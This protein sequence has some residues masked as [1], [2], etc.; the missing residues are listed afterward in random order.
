V[1]EGGEVIP[2]RQV[3]KI[4]TATVAALVLASLSF[5]A[6]YAWGNHWH[7]HRADPASAAFTISSVIY[8]A[9]PGA[10][11]AISCTGSPAL[12]YPG[13]TR[14]M[15]FSVHNDLSRPITVENIASQ[16][17]SAFPTPPP[18]CSGSNLSLPAFS[19]NLVVPSGATIVG[20]G[21]PI[22]LKESHSNQDA[23]KNLTYHFS[24]TG[25]ALYTDATSTV[26]TSS[27]NPSTLGKPVTFT[28]VVTATGGSKYSSLP[29][30]LVTFSQ[31]S[32]PACATS[33]P[34]GTG[35]IGNGGQTTYTTTGLLAGTTYVEAVYA[36]ANTNFTGSTSNVV[37]QVVRSTLTGTSTALTTSPNP[38][39]VGDSVLLTA[40][41]ASLA[42][43]LPRPAP[44]TGT[45]DVF[46]GTP[47]GT[48]TLLGSGP[49][50]TGE[51]AIISTSS[52][53]AGSDSLYAV[54]VGNTNFATSTSPEISQVVIA[55]P[56]KC[57]GNYSNWIDGNS[58]SPTISVTDGDNFVYLFG[59]NYFVH[60][61]DGHDCFYAGNGNNVFSDG[62]GNDCF[63]VGDG[64]NA[65]SDGNGNDVVVAGK[66]NN[67]VTEGNGSDQITVGNGDNTVTVGN[68]SNSGIT[69]GNGTDDVTVGSG[70][71][72]RVTLGSGT[73]VVKIQGGSY[74]TITSGNGNETIYLGAGSYDTYDGGTHVTN[75]CHLPAPP[76]SWHGTAA[77]YY[78]DTITNCTVETS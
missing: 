78:H 21:L 70:S 24:F 3:R 28:A 29:T 76:S 38:S 11:P 5:T 27:P 49:L 6:A 12:L 63:N 10:F 73:D 64:N 52:L 20:P 17:S 75:V 15:V 47:T 68:G 74:D 1:T 46:M 77:G 37:S 51:K 33:T 32:T 35:I 53:P 65:F 4:I 48:H 18:V 2:S 30:G 8:K 31:C 43:P 9:P 59:G 26:L 55:P 41:V 13:V 34:L 40:T 66:G 50:N 60:G 58:R 72:N 56:S 23:C 25:T 16:L 69:V 14:C 67:N 62:N 7:H 45:V 44:V 71:D 61:S 19:G 22:S 42:N 54:Y 36:G 57:T 39:F